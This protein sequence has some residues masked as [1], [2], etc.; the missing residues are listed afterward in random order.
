VDD[1]AAACLFVMQMSD[2][3][4]GEACGPVPGE[5]RDA[6]AGVS[7]LNVGYGSD[8]TMKQL[9]GE[10]NAVVGFTGEIQWDTAQPDGMPKKLVDSS[11]LIRAGWKP[12]IDLVSG[13]QRTYAEYLEL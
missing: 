2:E 10:I 7:H 12:K 8:F 9:C 11:R 3:Q 1:M 4:Y 13:I 5:S 6:A